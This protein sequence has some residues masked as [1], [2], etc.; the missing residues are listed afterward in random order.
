[1]GWVDKAL[2]F[3][4][5][6]E[7]EKNSR[8]NLRVQ[9]VCVHGETDCVRCANSDFE[10]QTTAA[11]QKWE[12]LDP[13][14]LKKVVFALPEKAREALRRFP[15]ECTLAGGF[16]R[17]IVAGENTRDIDLFV[18]DEKTAKKVADEVDL[19]YEKGEQFLRCDCDGV[20][21]QIVWRYNYTT[22]VDVPN[23]FDYT[24]CKACVY[25]TEG[26]KKKNEEPGYR[27]ICHE[28]FYRDIARKELVYICDRDEEQST[29]FPRLLK[30]TAYG[31]QIGPQSLAEVIV[32]CC[33]SMDFEKG[34][35][36]LLMQLE[37]AF[38]KAN[39]TDEEWASLNKKYVKPKPK[40]EPPRPSY[41]S[42]SYGS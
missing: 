21:V 41:S 34:F 23:D 32:K 14:D 20:E 39:G 17:A 13:Q 24:V 16:I 30:Y 31:Y 42:Y 28:R 4:K 2:G 15:E 33:L 35:E 9:G 27:G 29:G 6:V 22:P 37:E 5:V 7:A 25:F 11:A 8:S 26:D 36:G 10:Q 18:K 3:K 19:K 12:M 40:P 38:K 1:M